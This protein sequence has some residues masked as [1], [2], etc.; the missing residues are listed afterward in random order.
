MA[1]E[2]D[3]SVTGHVAPHIVPT[4]DG[5][6]Q[7]LPFSRQITI[8]GAGF[9]HQRT[10]KIHLYNEFSFV[11]ELTVDKSPYPAINVTVNETHGL[12]QGRC[13]LHAQY[14]IVSGG[15]SDW[16]TSGFFTVILPVQITA[17]AQNSDVQR[18]VT[19]SGTGAYPG[20][21]I[22]I[23]V[24]GTVHG[25]EPANSPSWSV[26]ASNLPIGT[27]IK[28]VATQ[29]HKGV[30]TA[31][32]PELVVNV[33]DDMRAPIIDSPKDGD[34]ITNL[35]PTIIGTGQ[36][37]SVITIHRQ[38][39][40]MISYGTGAVQIGGGWRVELNKSLPEGDFIMQARQVSGRV[41]KLSSPVLITVKVTPDRPVITLP[42]AGTEHDFTFPVSGTGGIIGALMELLLDGNHLISFGQAPVTADRW[43]VNA[44]LDAPGRRS[45]VARQTWNSVPSEVSQPRSFD[46]RPASLTKVNVT[47]SDATTVKFDGDGYEGATVAITVVSGPGGA[48]PGEA[49]VVS[50]KWETHATNWPDGLY[51]MS[52]IQKVSNNAGGWIE[53]LPYLFEFPFKF[54]PPSDV[55]STPDYTTTLSGKGV[56]RAMVSLYDADGT[57][58]IAPDAPVDS[59]S[60]WSSKAYVEWGPT[61][62]RIVRIRQSVN[63]QQSDF[64]EHKVCIPPIAPGID[65]V[66]PEGLSPTFTGTCELNAQVTLVFSG[67]STPYPAT[68][69]GRTWSYQRAAPFA[70]DIDHTVTAT[71]FAAQQTSPAATETFRLFKPMIPPVITQ[72]VKD[73]EVGRDVIFQGSDGMNGATVYLWDYVSGDP[74]GDKKLT[75]DGP[76][77][78]LV[79]KLKFGRWVVRAKQVI[80]ERES[81]DSESHPF[82]VVLL[83]PEVTSPQEGGK[84]TRTSMIEGKGEPLGTVDVFLEGT[85]E[86]ILKQVPIGLDGKWKDEVTLPVGN[87]VIRARQYFETQ[88]SKDSE[89]VSFRVVPAPPVLETPVPGAHVGQGSVASGFGVPQDTIIVW[90]I[91]VGAVK[92]GETTVQADG[93]WSVAMN[94]TQPSR[95]NRLLVTATW[96]GF[97]SDSFAA[98]EVILGTYQPVI[99]KPAEGQSVSDPVCFAGRGRAGVL[100]VRSWVNPERE[101]A[102][103]TVSGGSWQADATGPLSSGGQWCWIQQTITDDAGGATISDY[104]LSSRFEVQ[105]TPPGKNPSDFPDERSS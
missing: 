78:I 43:S 9:E 21:T 24:N 56:S 75:A 88:T 41:T 17:P 65:R 27:A 37:L 14:E 62:D 71:Q 99:E 90:M 19:I 80:D 1:D 84:L 67:N 2:T 28:I 100:Q 55:V 77:E 42:A 73:S 15:A 92:A 4:L 83:A 95:E 5:T 68:V 26:Q 96:E 79:E 57:T 7:T 89:W 74:L 93:T 98:R 104:V 53:S 97:Q 44:T 76:W 51:K 47:V 58:K 87:T 91:Q 20:A 16:G 61:F 52:V 64:V 39:D 6:T 48:A 38:G 10:W 101:W 29:T 63:A 82:D 66:P 60:Q 25:T 40:M 45:L 33:L 31:V 102:Q 103:A 49:K 36:P 13:Q 85:T 54:P 30:T 23:L 46:I 8:P 72:P 59:N 50:G 105:P 86:P 94:V 3:D 35:R 22:K 18:T 70:P 32:S 11:R 81:D 34:V 69:I 12:R